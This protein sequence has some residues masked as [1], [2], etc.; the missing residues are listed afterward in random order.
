M[1][2]EYQTFLSI[3]APFF[4]LRENLNAFASI[5]YAIFIVVVA[6]VVYGTDIFCYK[7]TDKIQFG[8]VS[9][10]TIF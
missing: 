6:I 8:D 7:S 4:F 3:L 9:D 1:L 2:L 10:L 5:I